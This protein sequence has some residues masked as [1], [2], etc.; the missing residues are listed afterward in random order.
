MNDL[1]LRLIA[2]LVL[3]LLAVGCVLILWNR[4]QRASRL[5]STS[6][7]HRPALDTLAAWE[8]AATRVLTAAE[9]QAYNVLARAY[10][11]HVILAQVPV[12]RFLRVPTR[13]SYREWLRRVGHQC[14]DLVLCDLRSQVLAVVSV[15]PAAAQTERALRRHAR[16]VKVLAAADIPLYLWAEGALPSPEGARR[17]I[18]VDWNVRLVDVREPA[19]EAAG[20]AAAPGRASVTAGPG[21]PRVPVPDEVL[22]MREPPS[23]TWFDEFDSAAA[24]LDETP[25]I[26]GHRG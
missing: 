13:H 18:G 22:E 19:L 16:L 20:M 17:M 9:C 15:R 8:P 7:T 2:G 26:D 10:P 5:Q 24:P 14:A 25:R 23:S 6:G 1:D 12:A 21:V 4:A 11:Q 3:L